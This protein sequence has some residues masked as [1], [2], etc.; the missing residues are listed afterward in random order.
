MRIL[1]FILS[2]RFPSSTFPRAQTSASPPSRLL[3]DLGDYARA[4]RA[5]ALAD[6]EAQPLVHCDRSN[7]LACDLD[8]VPRHHHLGA[9]GQIEHSGH[10]GGAE[11]ELRPVSGEERS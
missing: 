11:V 6:G 7:Q 8:V 4:D 10:V 9:F 3:Q 5:A 1:S 2:A